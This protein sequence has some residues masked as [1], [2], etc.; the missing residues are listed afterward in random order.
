MHLK[1][2][3]CHV[4]FSR[5]NFSGLKVRLKRCNDIGELIYG[6]VVRRRPAI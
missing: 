6:L 3:C 2:Q 4:R 5:A 1:N